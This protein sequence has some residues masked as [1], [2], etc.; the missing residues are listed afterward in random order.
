MN[1]LILLIALVTIGISARSQKPETV[2]SFALVKKPLKFYKEQITAWQFEIDKNPK[3]GLAWYNLYYATRNTIRTDTS[4]KRSQKE[5]NDQMEKLVSDMGKAVPESYEYNLCMWMNHGFDMSYYSY[6]EKA[7]ALGKDRTEHID[8]IINLGEI[9]R[10]LQQRDEGCAQKM[11]AGLMSPGMMYYNRNVL[12]GL[13][14]NAILITSGD[15]DT[16]PAFAV[17]SKGFRRD[18]TVINL[19]LILMDSYREKLFKE[20]GIPKTEINL[21]ADRD[22]PKSSQ[23]FYHNFVQLLAKNKKKAPVY[24]ALTSMWYDDMVKHIEDKLY[25]TGLAYKYSEEPIDE[26]AVLKKNFEQMF[27]LDYIRFPLYNDISEGLVPVIN[28]NYIVPMIKLYDHYSLCG[29][30]TKKLWIKELLIAVSKG[31][32]SE[33]DVLKHIE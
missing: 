6:L 23:T 12:A 15:N 27:T 31:T 18:V 10:D 16:Y 19:S 28:Q 5:K 11:K 1:R 32:E 17:Q 9:N 25:L 2:Y 8:F 20:L 3:N 29:D 24:M 33:K 30:L 22:D 21:E 26:R 4:D 7:F 13:E 14:T